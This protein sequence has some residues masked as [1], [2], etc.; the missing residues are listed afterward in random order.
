M[1]S[2]NASVA[3]AVAETVAVIVAEIVA[4]AIIFFLL[5]VAL[6]ISKR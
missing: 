4:V 1:S 5:A 2:F 3:V 6:L